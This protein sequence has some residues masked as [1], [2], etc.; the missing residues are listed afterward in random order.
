MKTQ[1]VFLTS[2]MISAA[3]WAGPST[4][5]GGIGVLCKTLTEQKLT[6][7]D[8]YEASFSGQ[9][10]FNSTGSLDR[11]MTIALQNLR[12]LAGDSR[13]VSPDDFDYFHETFNKSTEFVDYNLM[14]T[15][16]T[17]YSVPLPP[18]CHYEQIAIY[19]DHNDK[20]IVNKSLWQHLSTL[21]QA[22]LYYHEAIYKMQ[23]VAFYVDS[24]QT[25]RMVRELFLEG[26]PSVKGTYDGLVKGKGYRCFAGDYGTNNSFSFIWQGYEIRLLELAAE[27]RF[28][29]T[30]LQTLVSSDDVQFEQVAIDPVT[31][32]LKV[33]S[34]PFDFEIETKNFD[35]EIPIPHILFNQRIKKGELF[36]VGMNVRGR[37]MILPVTMCSKY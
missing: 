14:P 5:G 23:R 12:K 4:S 27:A 15:G 16:D 10:L 18:N 9:K 30:S 36:T 17:G 11:D 33:I 20:L 32:G 25:R 22:A 29:K 37:T 35:S 31:M 21:D 19:Q 13:P 1:I 26:G 34:T 7:L 8:L 24:A 28:V 6:V 3:A 2:L